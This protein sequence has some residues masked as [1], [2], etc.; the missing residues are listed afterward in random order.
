M[1]PRLSVPARPRRPGGFT[2]VEVLVAMT[3]LSLVM[4][5]LG[6]SIRSMGA[7]AERIDARSASTDQ[8]RVATGFVRE[9]VGRASAQPL[10]APGVGL[11]FAA[12]PDSVNW[13]GVMPARFGAA[14]RHFFRLATESLADGNT[15][16]VLR[17]VPWRTEDKQMPDWSRADSRV[18]VRDVTAFALSYDGD[19]FEQNWAPTWPADAR[20]LPPRMKLSLA[21]KGAEWPPIVVAIHPLPAG[22]G[23]NAR[24]VTGAD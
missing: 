20:K 24:F 6:S 2:L 18:L 5:V 9:V 15:G 22:Q 19:G 23:G 17:F 14:G 11:L 4:L 7:S 3:L 16:L 13:I 10:E 8:M 21:V 1:N 12:A